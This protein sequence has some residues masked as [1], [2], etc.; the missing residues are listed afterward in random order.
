MGLISQVLAQG[1]SIDDTGLGTTASQAGYGTAQDPQ[2][3]IGSI[4]Q[5]VLGF[6]GFIFFVYALYAG[7]LW[8]TA[9]GNPEQIKKAKAMITNGVIGL[10]IV[11]AAYSIAYY[12]VLQLAS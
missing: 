4:I 10:I 1:I 9:A 2:V 12:V 8:M 6:M 3:I 11:S 5:I 7:I